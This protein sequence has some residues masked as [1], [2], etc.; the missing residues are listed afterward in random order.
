MNNKKQKT[1]QDLGKYE[2]MLPEHSVCNSFKDI[3]LSGIENKS[4][5]ELIE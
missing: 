3:C 5:S 2:G 4:Y 1:V